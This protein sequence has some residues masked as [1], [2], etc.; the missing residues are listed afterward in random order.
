[1]T[2][3]W[4]N[5]VG[6]RQL[7]AAM[8]VLVACLLCV[9]LLDHHDAVAA[10]SRDA[11]TGSARVTLI[12]LPVGQPA[13]VVLKRKGERSR[14]LTRSRT[15]RKLRSGAW[16]LVLS[17]V[18]LTR[19]AGSAKAGAKVLPVR[20]TLTFRVLSG[21]RSTVKA[22]YGTIINPNARAVP[23]QIDRVVGDPTRPSA[24]IVPANQAPRA[25]SLLSS[26]PTAALPEGLVARVT[27]VRPQGRSR[28]IK[29]M[30]VRVTDVAPVIRYDGPLQRLGGRFTARAAATGPPFGL[31][32]DYELAGPCGLTGGADL[33]PSFDL[34]QP[35]LSADVRA[36]AWGGGPKADFT[37]TSRPAIGVR[38]RTVAGMF[39]QHDIVAPTRYIGATPTVPPIPV[40]ASFPLAV[41]AEVAGLATAKASVSW[42]MTLGFRTRRQGSRLS[43]EPVFDASGSS[44]TAQASLAGQLKVVP[45]FGA[46]LGLGVRNVLAISAELGTAVDYTHTLGRGCETEWQ[47]GRF[48]VSGTVGPLGLSSPEIAAKRVPLNVRCLP[49]PGSSNPGGT[50]VG[51]N[52][53]PPL[54]SPSAPGGTS[55]VPEPPPPTP[56]GHTPTGQLDPAFAGDG[57][58]TLDF[59]NSDFEQA[60]DVAV[61]PDGKIVIVGN[62]GYVSGDAGTPARPNAPTVVRLNADGN[63]DPTFGGSGIVTDVDPSGANNRSAAAVALAPGGDI[64]VAGMRD[65]FI[66]SCARLTRYRPDGQRDTAFLSQNISEF[67]R[68]VTDLAVAPDGRLFV[69]G[70]D[71]NGRPYLVRLTPSGN[72]ETQFVVDPSGTLREANRLESVVVE[73]D[74][75]V[76]V[77]ASGGATPGGRMVIARLDVTSARRPSFGVDGVVT[78]S[79][80]SSVSGGSSQPSKVL[81]LEDG[82]TIVGGTSVAAPSPAAGVV[83]LQSSGALDETFAQAGRFLLASPEA[84]RITDVLDYGADGIVAIGDNGE[85]DRRTPPFGLFAVSLKPD[86]TP[87][88]SFA[89]DGRLDISFAPL[90][91]GET[92]AA[93]R[94]PDGG[95]VIVGSANTSAQGLPDEWGV[96]KVR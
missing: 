10:S 20:P 90:T 88:P 55:T 70:G 14:R 28:R 63:L 89:Q 56:V 53:P 19:T 79:F 77:V 83:K 74:G 76:T 15:F 92:T 26:G 1:M 13:R 58:R 47:L 6:A 44:G 42:D 49:D 82:S 71:A 50:G 23:K 51:A 54:G 65:C 67:M 41:R 87:N 66:Y 95:L 46:E 32:I 86:G 37:I 29:L 25:G 2:E 85:T 78:E 40:Y 16:T 11:R 21:R 75:G 8:A 9:V 73:G 80:S 3:A 33:T 60:E 22:E 84:T 57:R 96:V 34:G 17:S 52:L 36:T 81:R 91:G 69:A 12:G 48:E 64:V 18:R 94:T 35:R 30:P 4:P 93:A 43:A 62:S 68:S 5:G 7:R 61:Q 27:A 31:S 24:L 45:S 39:C 38:L 72:P 59:N